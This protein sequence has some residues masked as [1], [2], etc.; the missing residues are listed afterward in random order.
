[1]DLKKLFVQHGEKIGLVVAGILF[2][3]ILGKTRIIPPE[4][5]VLANARHVGEEVER[6]FN[7]D[8]PPKAS[9]PDYVADNEAKWLSVTPARTANTWSVYRP[10][11]FKADVRTAVKV[12]E[13]YLFPPRMLEPKVSLGKVTIAWEMDPKKTT[14]TVSGYR[15]YRRGPEG[16]W[17]LL[18]KTP[19]TATSF[20]DDKVEPKKKYTYKVTAETKDPTVAERD[21]IKESEEVEVTTLGVIQIVFRGGTTEMAVI[22]VRKLDTGQEHVFLVK[23]G[24]KIGGIVTTTIHG[25]KV[26]FS[27]NYVLNAIKK[28]KRRYVRMEPVRVLCRETNT[29][30]EKMVEKEEFRTEL[31]IY[32]TDDEGKACEMWAEAEARPT[33]PKK[34]P[35]KEDE[36][37]PPEPK[38]DDQK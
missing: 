22:L 19:I 5:P 31:K 21:R 28:E 29:L 34:D 10:T 37:K 16:N 26:D 35:E 8:K 36:K 32:Y 13:K 17:E 4:D 23:P 7:E 24:S 2:L 14:A 33:P 1:M 27:T 25:T 9:L 6:R 3:V 38:E 11:T 12:A 18:T 15:V 30:I 20:T